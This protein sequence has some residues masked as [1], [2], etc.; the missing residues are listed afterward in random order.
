MKIIKPISGNQS[1]TFI[2][3]DYTNT[4]T[5][6]VEFYNES[7]KDVL[8]DT[9]IKTI[10]NGYVSFNVDKDDFTDQFNEG[11]SYQLKIT[12][13]D[14]VYRG[15]LFVTSQTTQDYK[16]TDGLYTYN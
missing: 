10:V 9:Y 8:E 14:I 11:D 1:I 2:P 16:L 4:T 7:T 13:G 15:K 6:L 12:D 3:R 5:L